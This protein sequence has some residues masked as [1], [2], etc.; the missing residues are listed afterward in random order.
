MLVLKVIINYFK[1]PFLYG[2]TLSSSSQLVTLSLKTSSRLVFEV[3]VEVTK[4]FMLLVKILKQNK[5]LNAVIVQDS[6]KPRNSAVS[7]KGFLLLLLL[8]KKKN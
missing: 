6:Q 2:Q 7:Y 1:L 3:I 8:L 5:I 4:I